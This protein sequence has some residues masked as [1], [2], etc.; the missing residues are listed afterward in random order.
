MPAIT[1]SAPGKI[2]LFG[3]HAVVYN[4]PAIA[5]PF[6][7]VRVK[8]TALADLRAPAGRVSIDAPE[9]H[10]HTTLDQLTD[11]NPLALVIHGVWD[12]LGI[13][14]MP[15]VTLRFSSTIPLA[16]GLG[17]SAA[18]AVALARIVSNFVG[19]PLPDEQVSQIAFE[20]EKRQHGNPSGIDNTVITF[21]KPVFYI[22]EKPF[23][24]LKVRKPLTLVVADSGIASSTAEM[25]EAL[26]QR[27]QTDRQSH[28]AWFDSIGVI[29]TRARHAIETGDIHLV[30][31]L[32]TQ[33]HDILRTMQLSCPELDRLVEAALRAGAL[34]AKLSGG[35][36]GGNM[37]AL[38]QAGDEEQMASA[39]KQAGAVWARSTIVPAEE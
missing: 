13:H 24:L 15:A 21:A 4:R 3:E 32:M 36:G 23:E 2:I 16:A 12:A 31:L 20:A 35:G 29:S 27:W 8:I 39:L 14:A 26:R 22:R 17:S 7:G 9:I 34:G 5:I 18:S 25:V 37:F 30:G 38:V 28:D 19:H 6:M 1:S 33:N 10:L 11:D